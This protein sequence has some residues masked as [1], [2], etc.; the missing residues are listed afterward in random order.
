M[1]KKPLISKIA[2]NCLIDVFAIEMARTEQIG[3]VVEFFQFL[4]SRRDD[5]DSIGN[6]TGNFLSHA[7]VECIVALPRR[8]VRCF[9]HHGN[10]AVA[11][12]PFELLL[13]RQ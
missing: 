11:E 13:V 4:P 6:C 3:F 7:P 9:I 5:T 1:Q 10:Q 8:Q 2:A 12:I